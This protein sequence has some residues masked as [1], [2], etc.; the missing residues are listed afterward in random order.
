M[1]RRAQLNFRQSQMLAEK[2]LQCLCLPPLFTS[3]AASAV[4]GIVIKLEEKPVFVAFKLSL[5]D[6]NFLKNS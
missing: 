4:N 6:A 5:S 1:H 2:L 3:K